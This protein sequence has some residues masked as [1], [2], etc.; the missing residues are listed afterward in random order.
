MDSSPRYYLFTS[1]AVLI[2]VHTAPKCGTELIH[3]V[4]FHFRYRRGLI[5]TVSYFSLRTRNI[6]L[7]KWKRDNG[8]KT[9]RKHKCW[10]SYFIYARTHVKLRDSGSP[11]LLKIAQKSPFFGTEALSGTVFEPVRRAIQYNLNIAFVIHVFVIT[12]WPS[13]PGV[14]VLLNSTEAREAKKVN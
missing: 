4:T 14:K 9:M 3:Y 6:F 1:D 5:S 2:P 13:T 12:D 10:A 8:W 11:P 7:R